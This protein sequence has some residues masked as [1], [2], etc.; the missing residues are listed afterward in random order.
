MIP[1]TDADGGRVQASRRNLREPLL[2]N[3]AGDCVMTTSHD[4]TTFRRF[5]T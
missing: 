4:L 2:P 1:W 5:T 3:G